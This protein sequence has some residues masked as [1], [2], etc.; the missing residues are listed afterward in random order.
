MSKTLSRLLKRSEDEIAYI[1]AKLEGSSGYPSEDVRILAENKHRLRNKISQL[2]LDPDDTTDQELYHA[3][4]AR[5]EKDS[6][7]IDKML[8]SSSAASFGERLNK[9]TQLIQHCADSDETWVVKSSA[10]RS[11]LSKNPPK[12]AAKL[13]GYRTASS[14]IKREDTVVAY[15]VASQVES[16]SWR[17]AMTAQIKQ[18]NGSNHEIRPVKILKF[19]TAS[20]AQHADPPYHVVVEPTVGAV[21][22]W[23]S[24]DLNNASVLI[25][26]LLLLDGIKS[27]NPSSYSEALHELNPALRW[28]VDAEYL[29]SD[30]QTPISLNIKDVAFNH[31]KDHDLSNAVAHNGSHSLWH[32]LT[33]RYQQITES[34]SDKIN[35]FDYSSTKDKTTKLPSSSELAEEYALAE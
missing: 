6:Q 30:G 24:Q 22:L 4:R 21:A 19:E 2:G 32:E 26:T 12:H 28:W 1:I 14:M 17:K 33:S 18:L 25:L 13:L 15:L 29:I 7:T 9:A 31:F 23:P 34:V 3:L 16:N 27:L 35:D 5:F 10:L 8:G 11:I 20:W